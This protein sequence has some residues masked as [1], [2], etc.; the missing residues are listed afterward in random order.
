MEKGQQIQG[1]TGLQE[2]RGDREGDAA[3]S[4]G[5][6]KPTRVWCGHVLDDGSCELMRPME[7]ANHPRPYAHMRG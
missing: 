5:S 7:L 6:Y 4:L 2:G 1:R 3:W